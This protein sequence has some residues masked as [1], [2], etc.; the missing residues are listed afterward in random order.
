DNNISVVNENGKTVMKAESTIK[1]TGY[2]LNQ[3]FGITA[4]LFALVGLCIHAAR[5]YQLFAHDDET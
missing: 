4:G 1:N 3:T 5:K 2:R